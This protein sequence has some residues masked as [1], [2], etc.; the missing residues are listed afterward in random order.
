[1]LIRCM[2]AYTQ[3]EIVKL[4]TSSLKLPKISEEGNKTPSTQKYN[5]TRRTVS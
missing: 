3:F 2:H 5:S 4:F 1:M